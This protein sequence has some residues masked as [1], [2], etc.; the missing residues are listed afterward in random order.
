MNKNIKG[1]AM[2]NIERKKAHIDDDSS[3]ILDGTEQNIL[4]TLTTIQRF[5]EISGFCIYYC[6]THAV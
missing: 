2:V 5:S 6:K 4:K 3:I 1:I